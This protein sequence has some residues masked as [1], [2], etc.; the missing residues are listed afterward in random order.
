VATGDS[1]LS[2][3]RMPKAREVQGPIT[4]GAYCGESPREVPL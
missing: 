1:L 2:I 4:S 3:A